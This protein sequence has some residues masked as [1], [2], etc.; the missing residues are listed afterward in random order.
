M[1][2]DYSKFDKMV[3]VE[4]LA[5]DVAEVEKNGGTGDYKEVPHGQYEVK[6]EK[7]EL[8]ESKKGDPMVSIW[9]KI[10]AG[11]FKNS[12]IFLNQLVNRDF[13]FHIVN[14]LLRA[15]DTGL[16]I[17]FETYKQ[18]GDL[19]LNVHE[20]IDGKLE[21]GLKYDENNKGYDTFEITDV[22]EVE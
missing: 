21:F 15:M 16:D 1:A 11:E 22:F 14:E 4:Q 12:F 2:V 9:F 20:A 7:M 10:L 19:L 18:Y 8:T 5:K 3:D 13:Q 17:H 6:V